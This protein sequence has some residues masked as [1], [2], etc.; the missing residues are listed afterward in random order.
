[1][2]ISTI[3]SASMSLIAISPS[4]G[5]LH[6]YVQISS[7]VLGRRFR[8]DWAGAT[9]NGLDVCDTAWGNA[10]VDQDNHWSIPCIG[11]RVFAFTDGGK[12]WYNNGINAYQ[13]DQHLDNGRAVGCDPERICWT[14]D[15]YSYC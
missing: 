5:C 14:W 13:I 9:D 1:M 7:D 10:R 11:T 3:L 8:V 6:T 4:L 2:K 15:T 12:A